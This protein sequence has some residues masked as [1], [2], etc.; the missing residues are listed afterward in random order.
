MRR[1]TAP[2]RVRRHFL[3]PG[4]TRSPHSQRTGQPRTSAEGYKCR[5]WLPSTSIVVKRSAARVAVTGKGLSSWPLNWQS[6]RSVQRRSS[7][8]T[9]A[10]SGSQWKRSGLL[11]LGGSEKFSRATASASGL[12]ASSGVCSADTFA[13]CRCDGSSSQTS[14]TRASGTLGRHTVS[15]LLR[16]P[17]RAFPSRI[18]DPHQQEAEPRS[19]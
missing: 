5:L 18:P 2:F 7:S 17:R 1:Q 11:S 9:F 8:S 16:P 12:S 14:T 15:A 13:G 4:N 10:R 19:N 3:G 6:L